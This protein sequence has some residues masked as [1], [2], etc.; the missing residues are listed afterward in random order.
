LKES[1]VP[2]TT[3]ENIKQWNAASDD[4]Q[5]DHRHGGFARG[6]AFSSRMEAKDG[7]MGSISPELYKESLS[8]S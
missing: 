6:G 1:G 7:S 3:P 2:I 4:W 8:A 5:H